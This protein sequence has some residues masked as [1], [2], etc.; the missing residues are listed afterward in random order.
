MWLR[1]FFFCFFFPAQ[2]ISTHPGW[3]VEVHTDKQFTGW[4]QSHTCCSL[5]GALFWLLLRYL[6]VFTPLI[7]PADIFS[8]VFPPFCIWL[9]ATKE[10]T[11]WQLRARNTADLNWRHSRQICLSA[12]VLS[13]VYL[14]LPHCNAT[15][16][17]LQLNY[18]TALKHRAARGPCTPEKFIGIQYIRSNSY[19]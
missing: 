17:W 5:P 3:G 7:T 9:S 1:V 2:S 14:L 15:V 12:V 16:S 6:C 11:W 19:S 13:F 4:T 18:Q 8:S 10:Q